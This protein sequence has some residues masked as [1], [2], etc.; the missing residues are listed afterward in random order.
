M[1]YSKGCF[2]Y[3]RLTY[4]LLTAAHLQN[5]LF[6]RY[7]FL[8]YPDRHVVN[9]NAFLNRLF[10]IYASLRVQHAIL[11]ICVLCLRLTDTVL[12]ATRLQNRIFYRFVFLTHALKK[13]AFRNYPAIHTSY[14][15]SHCTTLQY[16]LSGKFAL[17]LHQHVD[18][19]AV[20]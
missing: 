10:Y 13:I 8:T 3:L 11:Q 1:G 20:T 14:I 5:R 4:T 12:T 9:R 15:I 17:L 19:L 2:P 6:C 16:N 18:G 7:V